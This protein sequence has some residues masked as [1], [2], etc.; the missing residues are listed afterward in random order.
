MEN[1]YKRF[2]LFIYGCILFYFGV[3]YLVLILSYIKMNIL[4]YVWEGEV[5]NKFKCLN[6]VYYSS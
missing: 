1:F 4:L 3:I 5:W 2:Y 6:I